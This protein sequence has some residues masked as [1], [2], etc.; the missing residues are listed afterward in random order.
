M[1]GVWTE[2][3]LEG[4]RESA[5]LAG[6]TASDAQR[7]VTRWYCGGF[8]SVERHVCDEGCFPG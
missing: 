5:A 6:E 4:R 7:C 1:S 2:D 8:I 3:G